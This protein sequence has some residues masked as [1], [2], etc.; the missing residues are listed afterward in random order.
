MKRLL[1]LLLSAVLLL[2]LVPAAMAAPSQ[3]SEP[4]DP[5]EFYTIGEDENTF[6]GLYERM[7]VNLDLK[8]NPLPEADT[9]LDPMNSDGEYE[10]VYILKDDETSYEYIGHVCTKHDKLEYIV[11][12]WIGFHEDGSII[13]MDVFYTLEGKYLGNIQHDYSAGTSTSSHRCPYY[14]PGEPL[15]KA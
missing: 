14:I 2:C 3:K 11:W 4:V 1:S 7:C 9:D 13:G 15:N 5:A 10:H 12:T 6:A 8:K